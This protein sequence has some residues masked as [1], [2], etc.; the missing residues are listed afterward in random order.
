MPGPL[1]GPLFSSP[2]MRQ[3]WSD[4]GRLQ[5]LLDFEAGL[6]RA[7][8]KVG[9]IPQRAAEV[10]SRLCRAESFDVEAIGRA[11]AE[12]GNLAIPLVAR[13]TALVAAKDRGAAGYVHWGATSQD[14]IDTGL[15][16]QIRQGLGALEEDADRLVRALVGLAGRHAATPMVGRTWLQHAVPITFGLKVAGWL[17]ATLRR[18][19]QLRRAGHA[20]LVVQLGG[21]AGTLAAL[22]EKG[23]AVARALAA[24]LA[25]DVPELPWHAHRD[26]LA[27]LGTALG[28]LVG[29]L[30]KIARD[31]SLLAQTEVGEASEA[32]ASGRGG[33]SSMPH[34]R[35]PVACAVALSAAARAP[36]L[37]ATL[38]AA[39]PQE[40]ERGLGGWHAEWE[41]L[42]EL[43]LLTSGALE[44]LAAALGGLLVAPERMRSNLEMSLG[45]VMSESVG[46]ALAPFLGREGAHALVETACRRS[47]EEGRHLRDVL[48]EDAGVGAHLGREALQRLFDPETQL[49]ASE[50]LVREVLARLEEE[51]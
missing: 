50:R 39:M 35:N 20:A 22:G 41:T 46:M 7:E 34:K 25:L 23:P 4:R 47:M 1:M 37:V 36:G 38:L 12:S 13:L 21:A 8:A 14:A 33:S 3:V 27:D 32:A 30:G 43:F 2:G 18:R 19:G 29:T 24:E 6:A 26:R 49:R 31:V 28:V 17:Q 40:H 44:R 11:G 16:L 15:V 5:A 9:V 48:G 45:L 51:D 42:P 10:V